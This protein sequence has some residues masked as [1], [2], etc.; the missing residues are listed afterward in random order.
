MAKRSVLDRTQKAVI[1]AAK[2]GAEG[3]KDAA[4]VAFGAAASAAT[5]VAEALGGGPQNADEAATSQR[6][7]SANA[8]RSRRK[9]GK[10]TTKKRSTTKA[11]SAKNVR[12]AT[13]ARSATKAR[14]A[15][16][17]TLVK[18]RSPSTTSRKKISVKTKGVPRKSVTKKKSVRGRRSR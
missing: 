7:A 1:S 12:T 16:K 15:T 8:T 13:K 14:E 9:P 18:K 17:R 10:A 6:T 5:V 11:R 4:S 2:T 3:V